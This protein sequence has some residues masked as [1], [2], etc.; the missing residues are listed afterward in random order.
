[1]TSIPW[2]LNYNT[3]PLRTIR[4]I[5]RNRHAM[6]FS[7]WT[8]CLQFTE[9]ADDCVGYFLITLPTAFIIPQNGL[10]SWNYREEALCLTPVSVIIKI[11]LNTFRPQVV[12]MTCLSVS[13]HSV[14]VC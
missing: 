6:L 8:R 2:I 4:D 10:G 3:N 1:M 13:L 12:Q 5:L 7:A 11:Q 9:N 14:Y